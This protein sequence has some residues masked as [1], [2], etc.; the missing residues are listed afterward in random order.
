LEKK[1]KGNETEMGRLR[2]QPTRDLENSKGFP[3]FK[4]FYKN[5]TNL[6]SIQIRISNESSHKIKSNSTHQYKI[7]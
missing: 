1:W 6:D 2:I 5:Q 4:T 7:K 3:I